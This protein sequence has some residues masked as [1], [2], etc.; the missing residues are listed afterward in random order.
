VATE[1]SQQT[2]APATTGDEVPSREPGS[3]ATNGSAV[4]RRRMLIAVSLAV[5]AMA[6]AA[7][8]ELAFIGNKDHSPPWVDWATYSDALQ[9][10]LHGGSVFDPRQLTGPYYLPDITTTGY[11]YPPASL[12][13]FAPFGNQPIGLALWLTLNVGLLVSGVFAI[14]KRELGSDAAMYLGVAI[15]PVVMWIGFLNGLAAGNVTIGLSGVLAWAW[16]V[17]RERT[18]PAAVAV[19]AVA[20]M[21]PAILVC[22]T[23][24]AKLIRSALTA[25]LI[26]GAWILITLPLVGVNSWAD[27]F[28]AMGNAQPMCSWGPTVSC[29]LQPALGVTLAK[30]AAF[31]LAGA[32]GLGAV[33]V[34]SDPIAFTMIALAWIVPV[35]DLSNYSLMPLFVVWVVAFAIGVRRLRSIDV[36]P[37]GAALSRLASRARGRG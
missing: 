31:A 18:A 25:G 23:T 33:F 11:V 10:L 4:L 7:A 30:L 6:L 2:P 17:G 9:R 12:L 16:A 36:G 14:L 28:R 21:F 8:M 29:V 15:L 5:T 22:W 35:S 24:P 26:A 20:K 34:R 19:I 27:F 1:A 32:L 13:L 37:P 3:R